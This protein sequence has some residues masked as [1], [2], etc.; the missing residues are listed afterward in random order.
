MGGFVQTH[1]LGIALRHVP[2][3]L[4][5]VLDAW[6]HRQARARMA[7]RRAALQMARD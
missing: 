3:P 6:A 1:W 5:K 4:M 2:A 7:R